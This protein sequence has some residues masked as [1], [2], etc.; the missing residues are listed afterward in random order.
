MGGCSIIFRLALGLE[1]RNRV[2]WCVVYTAFEVQAR[3]T[4]FGL[5][6]RG[7]MILV[8]YTYILCSRDGEPATTHYS[9]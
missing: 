7:N 3:G 5:N 4:A 1:M 2:C 6:A 9:I 8:A